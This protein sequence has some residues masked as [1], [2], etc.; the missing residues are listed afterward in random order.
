MRR[1]NRTQIRE[2][3]HNRLFIVT[4]MVVVFALVVRLP[5][6]VDTPAQPAAVPPVAT[7]TTQQVYDSMLQQGRGGD[8]TDTEVET[9]WDEAERAATLQAHSPRQ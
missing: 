2:R 1:L 8:M 9:L 5:E 4:T 7:V 3:N 6:V